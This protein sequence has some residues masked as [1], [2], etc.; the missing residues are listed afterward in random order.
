MDSEESNQ[1]PKRTFVAWLK[2][3]GIVGF[4][5]FLCKG[6]LWLALPTLLIWFGAK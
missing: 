3:L 1:K 2:G 4:L 5:F 6:L